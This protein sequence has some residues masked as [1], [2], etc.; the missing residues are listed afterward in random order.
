MSMGRLSMKAWGTE[1]LRMRD[2]CYSTLLSLLIKS[3]WLPPLKSLSMLF[4]T[5]AVCFIV[6]FEN[7]FCWN[8]ASRSFLV[9]LYGSFA[10]ELLQG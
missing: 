3:W 10:V 6:R 4:R 7:S 9:I 1:V 8:W 5:G 2:F